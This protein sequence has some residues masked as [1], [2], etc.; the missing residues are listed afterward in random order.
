MNA[1]LNALSTRPVDKEVDA[2]GLNCPL[3]ILRTKKALNEMASGEILRV[4]STDPASQRDFQAFSRQTG[5]ALID[6]SINDGTF[7]Y[8]LRRK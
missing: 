7:T 5:N 4:V 8:L 1:D 6:Q 2:R 3:P